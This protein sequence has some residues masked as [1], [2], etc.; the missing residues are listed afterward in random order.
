MPSWSEIT[1][2]IQ[3][4]W[5][6]VLS[7]I[8]GW[9]N[10]DFGINPTVTRSFGGGISEGTGAGRTFPDSSNAVGLDRVPRDGYLIRAH[11][12][13][14]LLDKTDADIWRGGGTSKIEA[15]LTQL[16]NNTMGGQMVVLDTG[17][18]VGQ[19]APAM[20]ARLATISGR[21]GRGN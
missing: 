17:V 16:V 11:K 10:V 7:A 12:D 1:S 21:K 14:T 2:S 6:S 8:S 9:F 4:G 19:L 18:M 13:E 5:Q 3:A 15:L 20:D